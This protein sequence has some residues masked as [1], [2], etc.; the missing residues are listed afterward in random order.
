MISVLGKIASSRKNIFTTGVKECACKCLGFLSTLNLQANL[1]ESIIG[2]P[3]PEVQFFVGE[4][5]FDA[6]LGECSASRR[7]LFVDTEEKF[8]VKI[9]NLILSKKLCHSNC[10]LRQA[11]I[12]WLYILSKNGVRAK[13]KIIFDNLATIQLAFIDGLAENN[14][15]SHDIATK[16]L[17][18]VFESANDEQKKTMLDDLMAA[19]VAGRKRA[20]PLT[21]D[22]QLF[23]DDLLGKASGERLATYREICS[24]ASECNQPDLIYKFLQI[25][26]HNATW[27]SKKGAAF[28]FSVVLQQAEDKARPYFSQLI[29]KLYRYRYDPDMKV[30]SAMLSLWNVVISSDKNVVCFSNFEILKSIEL[31]ITMINKEWRIRE[32][33][34]LA[35]ADFLSTHYS[36]DMIDKFTDL[37]ENLFRLIDDIKESVRVAANRSLTVLIKITR[38]ECSSIRGEKASQIL[39]I[40][41]PVLIENG[42]NSPVKTVKLLSLK[43]IMGLSKDAGIVLQKHLVL[44]IPCL[45]DALSDLEPASLNFIAVRSNESEVEMIDSARISLA[46]N[47]PIMS[48]LFDLIPII[49]ENILPPL[50]SRLCEQLHSSFGLTTRTGACQFVINMCLR[51]QQLLATSK[52]ICD[53]MLQTLFL[54]LQDRNLTIRKQFCKTIAHLIKYCSQSKT[55]ILLKFIAESLQNDQGFLFYLYFHQCFFKMN[56]AN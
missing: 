38:R 39:S 8:I 17:G 25:A 20:V 36:T 10:H 46:H 29:P 32:S 12:I 49:D 22:T 40:V 31:L 6:I 37:Y 52:S 42:L 9:L 14:D 16:G 43:A 34:C 51:C 1:Y 56:Y 11:A 4:S 26:S 47:S 21:L 23:Y 2:P 13:M 35:L 48:S 3:Q 53:K 24:L 27:D 19:L 7:D 18:I 28:G 30:R 54:G 55:E 5:L 44:I 50:F 15:F 41:L 33:S 45:L